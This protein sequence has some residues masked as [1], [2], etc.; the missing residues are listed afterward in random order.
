MGDNALAL[1][2]RLGKT[3]IRFLQTTYMYSLM[4]KTA[5]V[6]D[7]LPCIEKP[8]EGIAVLDADRVVFHLEN[9]CQTY[10]AM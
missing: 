6:Y 8:P 3:Q 10:L 5:M 9:G 2:R 7:E 1:I 4:A